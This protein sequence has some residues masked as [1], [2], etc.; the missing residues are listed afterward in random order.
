MYR[1]LSVDGWRLILVES[2]HQAKERV[3]QNHFVVGLLFFPSRDACV[4]ENGLVN[5]LFEPTVR[6]IALVSKGLMAEANIASELGR[7]IT[8]CCFDFHTLPVDSARLASALGHAYGMARLAAMTCNPPLERFGTLG[9]IGR[10]KVMRALFADIRRIASDDAPVLITGESGTGKELSALAIH[11][12]SR[13]RE[14]PFVA[15]DCAALP[16]GLIQ[17]ELFGYERGAFTGAF[18]RKLGRIEQAAG[19]TLFLDEIGD[20]SP[21]LQV[22]LL[23]FLQEKT[24]RRLGGLEE[25]TVDLRVIAATHADLEQRVAENR[26]REDLYYRLD[27]L[28]LQTPPLRVRHGDIELLARFFLQ[29]LAIQRGSRPYALTDQALRVMNRHHWPGNVRE[30]MNRLRRAAVM[31][32]TPAIQARHLGLQRAQPF[33]LHHTLHEARSAA[34]Q[35]AVREALDTCHQ[36]VSQ[37]A[38]HLGISR[39]ALYRLIKKYAVHLSD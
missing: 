34:E 20:L 39:R 29:Q 33:A 28:R 24:F 23:R 5:F 14:R 18:Q 26:F 38:R 17:S 3:A 25:L 31:C 7:L 35:V 22:N 6:W 15:V 21:E 1:E 13:R 2:V 16:G 19:G 36:N 27:V 8:T 10:S 30:L 12:M 4:L 32:A 37:T 11:K 9:L